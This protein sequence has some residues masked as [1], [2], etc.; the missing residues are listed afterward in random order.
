MKSV[1]WLKIQVIGDVTGS[2]PK[3][4]RYEE[5]NVTYRKTCF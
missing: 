3:G 5:E 4:G 2:N 1:Y